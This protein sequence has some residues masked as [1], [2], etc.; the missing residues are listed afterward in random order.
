MN[1]FIRRKLV[2]RLGTAAAS[3]CLLLAIVPL[4]A[5]IAY[6]L[7]QG[8]SSLDLNFFT[9]PH[10]P[11]GMHGG[12]ANAIL[13]TLYIIVIASLCGL[14]I[15]LL[16]GIFLARGRYPHFSNTVRF[17]TDVIAGTPSII[18][19]IVVYAVL[20]LPFGFSAVSG[21]VALGL[22]MFPTV[23]RATEETVKL[24]PATIR[25]AALALG[26][27]EW[28]AVLRVT[29]P[30]A[31]Q[32]VVTAIMLGIARVAGETAPLVF[33]AFGNPNLPGSPLKPVAALPTEIWND[34][35][36]P[37]ADLHRQAWAGAFTL[38]AIVVILNL[39]ARLLTYRLS[40]RVALGA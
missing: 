3:L 40:R 10:L 2:D 6:V 12:M 13:G 11:S 23:T 39:I 38:F 4:A 34:A 19:G 21:G 36:S 25:D 32:G 24:V 27:P 20:V 35:Q 15:G 1:G 29:L 7:G 28:K 18:A 14:P 5:M 37:F 17:F 22:L 16:S 26:V 30:T 33:T 8:A 9:Q 31:A